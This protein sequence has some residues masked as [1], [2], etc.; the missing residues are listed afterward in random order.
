MSGVNQWSIVTTK[1]G[2]VYK[3][4]CTACKSTTLVV[5]KDQP[6]RAFCCGVWVTP[7]KETFFT[8]KL[9]REQYRAPRPLEFQRKVFEE[10]GT[11]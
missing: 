11:D 3:H 1:H 6:V 7:P 4:S 5:G 10:V 9:P 8:A 2:D